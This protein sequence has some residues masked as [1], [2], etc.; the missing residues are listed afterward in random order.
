MLGRDWDS[1][2]GPNGLQF[3]YIPTIE[4][5]TLVLI[6]MYSKYHLRERQYSYITTQKNKTKQK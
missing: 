1:I 5:K 4:S 6:I 2:R 3:L